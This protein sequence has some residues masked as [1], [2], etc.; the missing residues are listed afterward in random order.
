MTSVLINGEWMFKSCAKCKFTKE[1]TEF[2][3]KKTNKDG[4][5]NYCKDCVK[6]L[7]QQFYE[8]KRDKLLLVNKKYKEFNKEKIANQ[9]K[10]Y[11]KKN[12]TEI[13]KKVEKYRKL[14]KEKI[15]LREA[16][17]RLS[18]PDR[19]EKN[20]LKHREWAKKNREKLCL[21][22]RR[23][24]QNNKEKR[25]AHVILSRA[26]KKKIIM[27][28]DTCQECNKIAKTEG[29]HENYNEPLNVVWVCKKC[30]ARKSPKTVIKIR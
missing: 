24:Y 19:F 8:K 21:Y 23:W 25:R 4:L 17:K 28:S 16:K 27:R 26:I 15:S 30:H 22:Q 9:S 5:Y 6:N 2:T 10:E 1:I 14:N 12:K 29:H 7:N 18:D 11:Y 20:R 13:L 3:K